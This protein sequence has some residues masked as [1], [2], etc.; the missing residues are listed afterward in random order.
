MD[1]LPF[2][3]RDYLKSGAVGVGVGWGMI[4][5]VTGQTDSEINWSVVPT[6]VHG[7]TNIVVNIY[8]FPDIGI[9]PVYIDV[10]NNESEE[11]IL[12]Q[13]LVEISRQEVEETLGFRTEL[14]VE[15]VEANDE[16]AIRL[17]TDESRSTEALLDEQIQ[18]VSAARVDAT[19]FVSEEVSLDVHDRV[20]INFELITE[21][22]HS[23]ETGSLGISDTVSEIP[24]RLD[25]SPWTGE[26]PGTVHW[27]GVQPDEHSGQNSRLV[28]SVDTQRSDPDNAHRLMVSNPERGTS[29]A[30]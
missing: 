12:S 9:D 17:Y 20:H 26:L 6:P 2:S 14:Q 7:N 5:Q 11:S 28:A 25:S 3:R 23:E 16:V 27:T 4:G 22:G 29:D 13:P 24:E 10:Q 15:S 18:T 1:K 21:D 30:R 19:A 8:E